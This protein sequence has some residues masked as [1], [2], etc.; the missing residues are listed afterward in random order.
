[1]PESVSTPSF[2]VAQQDC[3]V[4]QE[5]CRGFWKGDSLHGRPLVGLLG[6][7]VERLEGGE[8]LIPARMTVDLHSAAPFAP[9]R[10][11]TRTLRAGGRLK[12]VEALLLVGDVECARAT[13]Q[14]LRV[15]E[16]L[17]TPPWTPAPW[18]APNPKGLATRDPLSPLSEE[19]FIA[20][21]WGSPFPRETWVREKNL[22]VAGE[23]LTPWSRIAASADFVSPWLNAL[24]DKI[25]YINTDVTTMV[26]RLPVGEW[27][28][29]ELI[30]HE[31]AHGIA[32]GHCRIH[33][34]AGP[35]GFVGATAMSMKRR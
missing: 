18:H 30:G 3:F 29:L 26:N 11:A 12:L 16:G 35:L 19:R 9:V 10:V 22:L 14:F 21:T 15:S 6:R 5:I 24:P 4:P 31:V 1:M 7:E 27:I 34:E 33:D 20:G 32:V 17:S 25:R 28:G 2:F 8:G 23:S 13:V